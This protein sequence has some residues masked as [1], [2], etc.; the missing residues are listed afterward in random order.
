VLYGYSDGCTSGPCIAGTAGNDYNGYMRV[1]RQFGG[2]PILA[3]FDVT[4]PT[5][6]KPPCL[7]GTRDSAASHLTWK[8]PDNGGSDITGYQILRS[9]TSGMELVIVANTGNT[10]TTYNDTTAD[11]NVPDYFYVVKAITAIGTGLQSNEIDL[12][13]TVT[14]PPPSACILPGLP[15]LTDPGG[16]ELDMLPGHDVQSLNIAEPFAF[17]PDKLVF[18]LKMA[19]LSTVPPDTY[20]PIQFNVGAT[21]YTVRM[22]TVAPATAVTPTFEYYQGAFN[23]T[24]PLTT[25]A[26]PAST[27]LPDGTIRIVVPRSGV[28]NPAIGSNLTMFLVRIQAFIVAGSITPDNM[29]DSLT[30]T[31][32]YMIVGNQSCASC[33]APTA[34]ADSATTTENQAVVISVLNNDA[35]GGS[36][37]LTLTAV[38]QPSNGTATNNGNGTVTYTPSNG[39]VG[40]DTFT[41]KIKNGCGST[42]IGNVTVT[43][44]APPPPQCVEDTGPQI[45]YDNGWH[46]VKA[47]NAS[48]GTYHLNT[49]KDVQ[50]A[51]TFKF[52]LQ[53]N[54]GSLQYFYATSSKGGTAQV[55]ID[56]HAPVSNATVNYSGG[57][58]AMRDP[59]FGVWVTYPIVGS[60]PH[61]FELVNL[62][63]PAYVDEFCITNGSSSTMTTAGP[64]TTMTSTSALAIGQSLL[65]NVMVPS[66]SLGFSVAAE[67][68]VNVPYTLVVIDPSGKVLGTVNSSSNGIASVTMPVS[69]SGLYVI[70]LVNVGV[71][72]VNI[73]TAAT[74]FVQW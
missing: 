17:A 23:A 62:T 27:F 1:A 56:G 20:W 8:M 63:G 46:T 35:D 44:N 36:P 47:S 60:G 53:S 6:P 45:A 61:K 21:P 12:S 64:G 65:Q 19:S 33:T 48:N 37:P 30:P 71:G 42:A 74:P 49:G 66:N 67:A 73:W 15:I 43:V 16:D 25:A 5:A 9:A 2:K 69:T 57:S 52:N 59:A 39:F 40:T 4:E 28:G 3:A 18:T 55:L 34:N 58:G 70:K 41:Y 11:P 26:D 7:S 38:T 54:T 68:N 72:P 14:P 22:S 32:S 13:I 24:L 51:L 29:P 31:G 10:K 50:H